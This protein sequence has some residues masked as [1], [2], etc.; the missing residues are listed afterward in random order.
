[1]H[2]RA[3][4]PTHGPE[5]HLFNGETHCRDADETRL[6]ISKQC[7]HGMSD[8]DLRILEFWQLFT[9]VQAA[10]V[11]DQV[12]EH[13]CIQAAEAKQFLCQVFPWVLRDIPSYGLSMLQQNQ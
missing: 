4:V 3:V 12:L 10:I 5:T 1:M 8:H 13:Y 7:S 11:L 6:L 9:I 2:N